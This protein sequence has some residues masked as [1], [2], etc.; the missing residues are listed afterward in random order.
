MFCTSCAAVNAPNRRRCA[1]CGSGLIAHP[2]LTRPLGIQLPSSRIV[3]TL[4]YRLPFLLL[5]SLLIVAGIRYQHERDIRAASY[6]AA[7]IALA[8]GDYDTALRDFTRASGYRDADR[9]FGAERETLRPYRLAYMEGAAALEARRYQDAIAA[10]APVVA[11]LPTYRDAPNLLTEAQQRHDA[12]LLASVATAE[13]QRDWLAAEQT[14]AALAA[15]HPGDTAL[16]ARLQTLRQEHGPLALAR[17]DGLY[18]V[19]PDGS[20]QRLLTNEVPVTMPAWDSTRRQIAFLA[21]GSRQYQKVDDLYVIDGDG[22]DLTKLASGVAAGTAPVWDPMGTRI[23]FSR[24]AGG[25]GFVDLDTGNASIVVPEQAT[26]AINPTWSPD[27]QTLALIALS[28]DAQGRPSS[29]IRIVD[30][31]LGID[32][33]LPGGPLPDAATISWNPVD[34]RLLVYRARLDASPSSQASGIVIVDLDTGEREP[35]AHGA[36]LVLPPVWSPDGTRVAYVEGNDTLRIRRP[37]TLGEAAITVAHP[38]SGDVLWTPGGSALLALAAQPVHPSFLIPLTT[39]AGGDG[40][41][42]AISIE[43]GSLINNGDHGPPVWSGTHLPS[44]TASRTIEETR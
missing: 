36:R 21:P 17:D 37:G 34:N 44:A 40:P 25:I 6:A 28:T 33:T 19:G 16:A 1:G 14:L 32:A 42:S 3:R 27:G 35:L 38:L 43:L 26:I 22:N 13:R 20:D 2:I 30:V 11:A 31:G 9:R 24:V 18:L 7:E 5:L 15:T 23:A 41:G 8:A 4:L 39:R 12:L 10:L 29:E